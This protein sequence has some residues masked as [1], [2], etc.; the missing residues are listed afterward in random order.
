MMCQKCTDALKNPRNKN[1]KSTKIYTHYT[2]EQACF[3]KRDFVLMNQKSRQNAKN[4]IEEDFFKL[5]NNTN[6]GYGCRNNANNVTFQPIIGKINEI[7]YI[8]KY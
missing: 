3:K 5:I 1:Q 2:F 8:K 7:S 6:F 4:A